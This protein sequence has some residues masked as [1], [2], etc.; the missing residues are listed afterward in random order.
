A[1]DKINIVMLTFML[2]PLLPPGRQYDADGHL[3]NWWT[4]S[5]KRIFL[6]KAQCFIEQ[7]GNV[8]VKEVNLTINGINTQGENIADYSGI[9]AAYL[10]R[11]F[12]EKFNDTDEVLPG[13]NLTGDQLFFLS[14]AMVKELRH[15]VQYYPHSPGKYR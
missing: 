9:R 2:G 8:T 10:V 7:Y 3:R 12:E 14:N 5:A 15:H 11:K 1:T 6:E 4:E 13:L